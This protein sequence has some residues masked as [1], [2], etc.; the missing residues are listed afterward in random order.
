[1]GAEGFGKTIASTFGYD[2]DIEAGIKGGAIQAEDY[3]IKTLPQDTVVGAG[4]TKLGRTDEMVALLQELITA[5][6][7]GGNVYLDG[8]KVGTAMGISAYKTQ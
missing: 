5:V 7:T 4:G 3:V 2:K 6:K 1:M 8:N